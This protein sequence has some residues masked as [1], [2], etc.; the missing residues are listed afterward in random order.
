[1]DEKTITVERC[2]NGWI[3]HSSKGKIIN[4]DAYGLWLQI[5]NYLIPDL[6]SEKILEEI[7]LKKMDSLNSKF[8]K[9]KIEKVSEK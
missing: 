8:N 4:D 2:I 5:G 6:T 7:L 9:V 3:F 1:M